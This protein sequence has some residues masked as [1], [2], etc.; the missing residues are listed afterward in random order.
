MDAGYVA[1]VVG[2]LATPFAAL[3]TYALN[4]RNI[5]FE[6]KK[7]AAEA[8][9][10]AVLTMAEV[11]DALREDNTALR[12]ELALFKEENKKLRDAVRALQREV[13]ALQQAIDKGNG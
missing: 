8:D 11:V 13:E 9:Q 12:E 6:G 7:T 10:I 2:L 4:K 3:V 1:L 5:S